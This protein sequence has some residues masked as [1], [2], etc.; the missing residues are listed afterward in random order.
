[1]HTAFDPATSLGGGNSIRPGTSLSGTTAANGSWIDLNACHG[2]CYGEFMVGAATGTPDSYTVTCKLQ[3]ADDSSGTNAEDMPTQ[4]AAVV[5]TATGSSGFVRG[6][7]SRRW[8][9]AV[10]TP[11]FVNGT[12][13]TSPVAAT[14]RAHKIHA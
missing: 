1:M 11:A 14:V 12:S 7:R 5:L 9:R 2:P 10:A 4:S 13:P 8:V 3:Q 6:V